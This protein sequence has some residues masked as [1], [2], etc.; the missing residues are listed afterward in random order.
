MIPAKARALPLPAASWLGA[1][2]LGADGAV[3][4]DPAYPAAGQVWFAHGGCDKLPHP[5]VSMKL[6]RV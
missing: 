1:R 6:I 2:K 5:F 3:A 4:A